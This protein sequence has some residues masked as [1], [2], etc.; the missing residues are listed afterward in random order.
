MPNGYFFTSP[1]LWAYNNKVITGYESGKFG[2]SEVITREQMALMMYRYAKFCGL[3][4]QNSANLNSYPDA[5]KV[6]DFS[7]EAMS[8]AVGTGL[9]QGDQ[10]TLNPQGSASRA[11][12]A[13][14]ITRFIEKYDL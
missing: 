8:W 12:C 7:R 13:T 2:P 3:N 4:T 1:V 6:S 5:G 14:I 11:H 10:G 9:I